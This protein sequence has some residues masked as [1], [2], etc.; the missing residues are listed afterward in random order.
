MTTERC[1]TKQTN[2]DVCTK[3]NN[4]EYDHTLTQKDYK[5][6]NDHLRTDNS[7]LKA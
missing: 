4:T 7:K 3:L 1:K 2:K 5:E 6:V